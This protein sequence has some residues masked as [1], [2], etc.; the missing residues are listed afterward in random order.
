MCVDEVTS[1][2]VRYAQ[3]IPDIMRPFLEVLG[4]PD[5]FGEV[6]Q[7][8]RPPAMLEATDSHGCAAPW[9]TTKSSPLTARST[10]SEKRA[11]ASL[12]VI[13]DSTR[14]IAIG[15]TW[16]DYGQADRLSR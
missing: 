12:N 9:V 7:P 3:R 13:V 6:A 10:T 8:A 1:R 11:L 4:H 5:L 14:D 16:S 15:L 2:F